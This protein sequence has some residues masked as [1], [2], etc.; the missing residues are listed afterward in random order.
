MAAPERQASPQSV[1]FACGLNSVRSP[2]AA[3]LFRH[4][5]GPSVAVASAGVRKADV[6]P[7][8]VAAMQEI[9]I[10]MAAHHPVSLED[11][12]DRHGLSFDLVITLAPEAHHRALVL[13][14]TT[15]PEVEYWPTPD[16]SAI[17][18]SRDM[19]MAAYRDVR[20]QL[21]GRIRQRFGANGA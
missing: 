14:G 10:D 9:G 5:I 11:L 21:T 15:G 17:E 18:G 4:L 7:F 8:A 13:S 19:R 6:D 3:Y 20:E 12:Q 2:M 1:L 16:P